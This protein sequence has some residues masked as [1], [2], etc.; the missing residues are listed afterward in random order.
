[1]ILV[2]KSIT[3]EVIHIYICRS[4]RNESKLSRMQNYRFPDPGYKKYKKSLTFLA[5]CRNSSPSKLLR[6]RIT[7]LEWEK[8]PEREDKEGR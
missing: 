7:G 8:I 5:N 1:M 3:F 6:G 2:F 4:E